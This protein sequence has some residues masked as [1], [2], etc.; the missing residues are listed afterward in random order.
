MGSPLI[1]GYEM[2]SVPRGLR[3]E[4]RGGDPI[5]LDLEDLD[6]YY[7][8]SSAYVYQ[9]EHPTRTSSSPLSLPMSPP[10]STST[11]SAPATRS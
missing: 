6:V 8:E 9:Y 11:C 7:M 3:A 4:I 10:S 2:D 5:Y 1:V